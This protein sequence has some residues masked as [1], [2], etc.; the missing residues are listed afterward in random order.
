MARQDTTEI[1]IASQDAT[2]VGRTLHD[3]RDLRFELLAYLAG[4]DTGN[5][6]QVVYP[7]CP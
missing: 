1:R 7:L 2:D 3:D 4:V 5:V 6:T